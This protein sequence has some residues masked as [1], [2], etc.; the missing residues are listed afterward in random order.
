MA[1]I[2]ACTFMPMAWVFSAVMAPV[3]LAD[4]LP[5]ERLMVTGPFSNVIS[6]CCQVR[7]ENV[8]VGRSNFSPPLTAI[9]DR[10]NRGISAK[11]NLVR[12]E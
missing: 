2:F 12:G 6:A 8:P 10:D 11:R 3:M 5:S 9:L 1:S 7:R 4:R